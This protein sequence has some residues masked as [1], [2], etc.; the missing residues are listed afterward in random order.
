MLPRS[1]TRQATEI[2][3]GSTT[4]PTGTFG[5]TYNYGPSST[6]NGN[7]RSQTILALAKTQTY[8]YD[9]L[10]RLKTADEPRDWSQTY[11]YDRFGN[12]AVTAGYL[13]NPTL[14]PQSLSA[15]DP[16]TNRLTASQYDAAGNQTRD[17]AARTF[18]YDAENRQ[19]TFNGATTYSY[20]GQGRRVKKVDSGVTTCFVYNVHG[21]RVTTA[22]SGAVKARHDYLPFGEEIP[23]GIGTRTSANGY[24]ADNLRQQFTGKERDTESG[25]DYFGAR[26]FSGPQGRFSS[27]DPSLKSANVDRPQTWNRY[28]YAY[29]T[30]LRYVDPDGKWPT[31][32]HERI[33]EGA[34][35]GLSKRQINELKRISES[36]DSLAHQTKA[37]NHEH[38][39]MSPGE[40]PTAA[41]QAI[42]QNIQ[43]H[44]QAARRVQGSSVEN[45]SQISL[46]A[47]NEFGQVLHTV[48]DRTSPAHTDQS[49]NPRVW[50]GIPV[51]D[52][53][54]AL[55]RQHQAEEAQI[56]AEQLEK[57]VTAARDSFR[58][59]FG[60]A[61]LQQ[62]IEKKRKEQE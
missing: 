11:D 25:L 26:Y 35:P 37:H 34:F 40:N 58:R 20:D 13:P 48:T 57:A 55:A 28:V 53:E 31:A 50:S 32:I 44:E 18:T 27:L 9:P 49:G 52:R 61:A 45:I 16:T 38:A 7:L 33:I 12:R 39:M 2:G 4:V 8:T 56:T 21:T 54:D 3:L 60:E 14:T 5:L 1:R 10:N 59:T 36:V 15:F 29:N 6:N 43:A 47:L 41:R 62:A 24:V 51:S 19:V 30:P 23:A 17:A 46:G 42:D 22:S